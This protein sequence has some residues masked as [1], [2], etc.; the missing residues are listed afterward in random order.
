MGGQGIERR[1]I[2]RILATAA[3]VAGV[4]GLSRWAFAM[5]TRGQCDG[6]NQ[7]GNQERRCE[8]KS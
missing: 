8:R 2:L 4:S 6:A 1:E 7:A 5:R 3:G